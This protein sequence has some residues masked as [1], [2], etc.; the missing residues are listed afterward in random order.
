MTNADRFLNAY[1]QIEHE[2]QKCLDLKRHRRFYDLLDLTCK[3]NPVINKYK[4]DLR[5]FGDLRN[6]IVHDRAD[7]EVIAQPND[8][9]VKKIEKIA[10]LLLRPPLVVPL[11]QKEV[12]TISFDAPLS[13]AIKAM[14]KYN[15]SQLPVMKDNKIAGLLT[16]NMVV[17]WMG[18]R[19][20]K[21]IYN[22]QEAYVWDVLPFSGAKDN[23]RVVPATTSLFDVQELFFRYQVKVHK[24]EAVL[25]TRKG[26]LDEQILG[27]I[28]NLDLPL[29]QREL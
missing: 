19:L 25:I 13:R 12:A 24:L 22:L 8:D 16:S 14:G 21:E 28:T 26:K 5:K 18:A 15:Y 10:R 6:A 17:R 2:L 23:Y 7:G 27:I 29:L 11:F 20:E 4:F 3:D 1:A 9:V